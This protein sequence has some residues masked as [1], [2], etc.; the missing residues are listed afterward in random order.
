MHTFISADELIGEGKTWHQSSLFEPVDG[1]EATAEEDTLHA[2]KADKS[3]GEGTAVSNPF[4][5]P[6]SL[7]S[8]SW[9]ILNGV[10]QKVLLGLLLDEGVDQKRVSFRVDILHH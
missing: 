7:L 8:H 10:E 1:T 5:G 9:N 6:L 4:E 2:G 3:C